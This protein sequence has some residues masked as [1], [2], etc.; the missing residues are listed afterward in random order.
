[1]NFV[2]FIAQNYTLTTRKAKKKQRKIAQK[3]KKKRP[4]RRGWVS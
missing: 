1:M 2:H 3:D 4:S